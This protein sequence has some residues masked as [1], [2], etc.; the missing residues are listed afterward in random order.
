M[1]SLQGKVAGVQ[2]ATSGS[3]GASPRV[4]I[5]G[6][7]TT[8]GSDP[9]YVVDGIP[10]GTNINF[11]NS[12]DIASMEILKDASST[13]VYGTRGSNGVIIITTKKGS[14]DTPVKFNVNASV[15]FQ[16]LSNPF[17]MA[18]AGEYE[19]AMIARYVN[20]GSTVSWNGRSDW[21]DDEGTDWW[22]ETISN[23]ALVQNYDISF[24][25][26]SDKVV[27][28][29]SLA[30]YDQESN[31]DTGE[32]QRITARFNTEYKFNDVVQFGIGIMPVVESWDSTPNVFSSIA[33]M[34]PTT[35]VYKDEEDWT[36]NIYDNYARSNNNEVWNPAATVSRYNYS[37]T[38]TALFANPYLN[39]VPTK[40]LTLRT[41]FGINT[42]FQRSDSFIP[43]FF[44]DELEQQ[45]QSW[46]QRAYTNYVDWNWTNT[47]N[48]EKQIAERH[49]INAMLGYTMEKSSTYYLTGS[50][51]ATPSNTEDLQY[52]S[53]GTMNE[54]ASGTD[55]YSSL[56]SYIGRIMYNYDHRYYITATTRIDGS[57]KFSSTNKYGTFPS[58]SLAWR[59]TSE[60]FMQD[61]DLFSNIKLRL[62]WGRVGNQNIDDSAYVSLIGDADYV[63]G[64][65]REVGTAVSQIGNSSLFWE[66]VEDYNIGLDLG[67]LDNRLSLTMD[68]YNKTS[69][70]MLLERENLSVLG[71]PMWNGEMWANVGSMRAEGF[72][73]AI[74]WS[75]KF[76]NGGYSIDMNIGSV[77]NTALEL[78]DDS[79]IYTGSWNSD[80]I[81]RNEAGEQI[82]Q[83]YGYVTDGLFQNWTEVYSHAS[84]NGDVLQ[85]NAQPGD[86]RYVDLNNDGVIDANDKTYIGNPFPDFTLGF[87]ASVQYKNFD[88]STQMYA[89]VGNDIYNT[90][91]SMYS[92]TSGTNVFAG[93]VDAAWSGE[94]T[95]NTLP[96]LSA[97]DANKNYSTV[98]DFFVEDGSYLRCK[99]LQLGY[100][101]PEKESRPFGV[102]FTLSVQNL[103]TLTSYSGADPE[104]ASM[105]SVTESGID[106]YSYPSPRTFLVG[107]NF[108]F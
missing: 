86:F 105:G 47:I 48:Y 28:S 18:G 61:Q 98:S 78:V 97:N 90:T 74:G 15:G 106:W 87:N 25:G 59:V 102:R 33:R 5:R 42:K 8:N 17:D 36:D 4:I 32:Y 39:I 38:K 69:K 2:V 43:E 57:S 40:G 51:E 53:A 49:N 30:Y 100:T 54:S 29:G 14:K 83:F 66:T 64:G 92:G 56:L 77:K 37:G 58:V 21:S 27:Y 65:D 95:S 12:G 3:P 68:Y 88:L 44:I 103:F 72:E 19:Q 89:S 23:P 80:Y 22:E 34:D 79:P 41:Q 10:V 1:N 75:D 73:I 45:S 52:V 107:A 67:L 50:S 9:L 99:L 6:V 63:F 60:E 55:E 31:Y 7:T 26:G 104:A 13:S 76:R 85:S 46:V 93:T 71:Y 62:G 35:S 96:R 11:L 108:N 81:I 16:M 101:I 91:L 94:G 70:D 82:S 24:S 20:D 84:E